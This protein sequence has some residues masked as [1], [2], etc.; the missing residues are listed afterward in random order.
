MRQLVK[1]V[2]E[3]KKEYIMK[4]YGFHQGAMFMPNSDYDS[5]TNPVFSTQFHTHSIRVNS[6]DACY[7]RF[8]YDNKK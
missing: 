6:S 2:I 4:C 7:V 3:K 8:T 1:M 5:Y